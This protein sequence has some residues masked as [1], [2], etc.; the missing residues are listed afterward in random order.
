MQLGT[1]MTTSSGES[2]KRALSPVPNPKVGTLAVRDFIEEVHLDT[3]LPVSGVLLEHF[4]QETPDLENDMIDLT[5]DQVLLK[6]VGCRERL[7]K[8]LKSAVQALQDMDRP[9]TAVLAAKPRLTMA[10]RLMFRE[11][12]LSIWLRSKLKRPDEDHEER[13]EYYREAMKW[14]L[15]AQ[16]AFEDAGVPYPRL[17]DCECPLKAPEEEPHPK[18]VETNPDVGEKSE[19][20]VVRYDNPNEPLPTFDGNFRDW[21]SFWAQFVSLV[22]NNPRLSAILKFKR[23]LGALT[24]EAR[25]K[26]RMFHFD[27]AN[28]PALK[29]YLVE[30]YGEPERLIQMLQDKLSSWTPLPEPC[31]YPEFSKYVVVAQEFLRDVVRHRPEVVKVPESI[32]YLIRTKLPDSIIR[33]WE[34]CSADVP[35]HSRLEAMVQLLNKEARVRRTIYLDKVAN[36]PRSSKRQERPADGRTT[37][38]NFAIQ[39]QVVDDKKCPFCGE[40]HA[41][42][43]CKKDMAPADRKQHIMR[44]RRCLRC[45]GTGHMA[46]ACPKENVCAQCNKPHH[47]LLHG[48]GYVLGMRRRRPRPETQ[49]E[50]AKEA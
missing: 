31:P 43:L 22:D 28:Y 47:T 42:D 29:R 14:I 13:V 49:Q 21:P 12:Q 15:E 24:G 40:D 8:A 36:Q 23:L 5:T 3:L 27:E 39:G 17:F 6:R 46:N 7:R 30:E 35:M 16:S 25:D 45:L 1:M 4:R 34:D 11:T 44:T 9:K 19:W 48:A 33:A 20:T 37:A 26:A 38:I 10:S 18:V 41:P 2:E 32:I 50:T